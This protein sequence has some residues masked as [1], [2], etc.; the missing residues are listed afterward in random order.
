MNSKMVDD[1]YDE[2]AVVSKR[3]EDEFE[4]SR[5]DRVLKSQSSLAGV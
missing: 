4:P 3:H 5:E 1:E 2:S